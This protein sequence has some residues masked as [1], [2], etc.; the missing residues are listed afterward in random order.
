MIIICLFFATFESNAQLIC[1]DFDMID[2]N[3]QSWHLYDILEEG[4]VVYVFQF[5]GTEANW[6]YQSSGQ[7]ADFYNL[8]GP[9]GS[10]Q[11]MVFAF[12][13]LD[14]NALLGGYEPFYNWVEG[15]QY[16]TFYYDWDFSFSNLFG[17]SQAQSWFSVFRIC[18]DRGIIRY[19]TAPTAEQMAADMSLCTIATQPRDAKLTKSTFDTKPSCPNETRPISVTLTNLGTQPLTSCN[20][21]TVFAAHSISNYAWSGNLP[22]YHSEVIELP[23]MNLYGDSANIKVIAQTPNGDVDLNHANDTI[24]YALKPSVRWDADE[25]RVEGL[26][27]G[28][29][30]S[31]YWDITGDDGIKIDSGGNHWVYLLDGEGAPAGY[32]Y[33]DNYHFEKTIPLIGDGAG[34][35]EIKVLSGLGY[36]VCCDYGDGYVRFFKGDSLMFEYT[37][38]GRRAYDKFY[39]PWVATE[40]IAVTKS[41]SIFPNPT[42]GNIVASFRLSEN[43]DVDITIYNL[44]GQQVQNVPIANYPN[45][46]HEVQINT[47]QL[48][49]GVYWLALR[50]KKSVQTV[51]FVVAR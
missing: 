36:G 25:I 29:G 27:D 30:P 9:N 28:Y 51:K 8:Y 12:T 1:P 19:D 6:E 2:Y 20:I 40:D 50:D 10:N 48:P 14:I 31:L 17:L 4:K 45:G 49:N 47:E 24:S 18:P 22:T 41:L 15:V 32:G 44:M 23:D 26:T 21:R 38:F 13:G 46:K 16:P 43:A 34:C 11:A 35:M 7:L 39:L 33:P 5:G 3:D 37:N 42:N